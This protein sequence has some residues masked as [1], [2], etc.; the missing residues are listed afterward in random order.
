MVPPVSNR[1]RDAIVAAR[2]P[3]HRLAQAWRDS[4]PIRRLRDAWDGVADVETAA[5][6]AARL[7]A[8]RAWVAAIFAPLIDA[9]AAD[10]LFDPP[11]KVSRDALRTSARIHDCPTGSLT[12]TLLSAAALRRSKPATTIV[13]PGR[14][15]IMRVHVGGGGTLRRWQAEKVAGD[16]TLA[17]AGPAHAL[18][19]LALDDDMV[20]RIDGRSDAMLITD[21][22]RDVVT[23][24]AT[25]R[26]GAA[27]VMREYDRH[28]GRARRGA[29]LDERAARSQMLLTLLRASGRGD[30]VPAFDAASRDPAFF[31]RWDA[32]RQWLA[33][34]AESAVTRLTEMAASDPNDDIR[35][36][37]GATLV[38]V[39]AARAAHA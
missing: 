32:M 27:P 9:L 16:F 2:A 30:S 23:L 36:L 6:H 14:M 25:L 21:A 15:S 18:P 38:Q 39:A 1:L 10:P 28:D 8:D 33:S 26:I 13:V 29:T 34:D 11:F 5:T 17:A 3:S 7:L 4:D 31:V 19:Q 35:T 22:A 12:A 24:T 37:A 20:L